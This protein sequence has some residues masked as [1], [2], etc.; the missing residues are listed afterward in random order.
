VGRRA[1]KP[2][3]D[4]FGGVEVLRRLSHRF[5]AVAHKHVCSAVRNQRTCRTNRVAHI[6]AYHLSHGHA[7]PIPMTQAG[8]E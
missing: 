8:R 7:F 3:L 4:G 1:I 6:F 5:S 2:L